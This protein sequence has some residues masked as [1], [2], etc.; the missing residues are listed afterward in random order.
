MHLTDLL[1]A[2]RVAIERAASSDFNKSQAIALLSKL[3]A[4]GTNL[5]PRDIERVLGDREQLQ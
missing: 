5:A 2:D 3:L 4:S 1:T